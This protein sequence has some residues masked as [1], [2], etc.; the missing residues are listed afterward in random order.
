MDINTKEEIKNE[1]VLVNEEVINRALRTLSQ[2]ALRK[3]DQKE[4]EDSLAL[5]QQGGPVE[6][7]KEILYYLD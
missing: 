2:N 7:L 6:K 4:L 5:V 3:E 1:A